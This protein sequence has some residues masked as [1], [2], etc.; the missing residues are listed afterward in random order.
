MIALLSLLA[1]RS[2]EKMAGV[3]I[4][5]PSTVAISFFFL[6][7]VVSPEKVAEVGPALPVVVGVNLISTSVYIYMA[8]LKIRKVWAILLSTVSSLTVW[9]IL[10]IPLAIWPVRNLFL[11]F[12]IYIVLLLIAYYFLTYKPKLKSDHILLKYSW[13][14]KIFRGIF[15]GVV[16]AVAV[17][18][19]KTLGPFWGGVFSMFPAVFTSSLIILHRNYDGSFLFKVWKNS[20]VGSLVF[21]SYPIAAIWTFP[22]FGIVGGTVAAYLFS[23]VVFVVVGR[24]R[25]I[26]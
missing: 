4:S 20:P 7:W 17:Y 26:F 2:S 3:I 6:G 11:S 16:V 15:G 14:E 19:G 25:N 5:L 12:G 21:C 13:S 18:L 8:R 22:A 1:E 23:L 10:A 9:F 24:M